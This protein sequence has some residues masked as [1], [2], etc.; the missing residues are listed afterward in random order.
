VKVSSNHYGVYIAEPY[1]IPVL[2]PA[3]EPKL[4][5]LV[6]LFLEEN[7]KVNLSA[8]RTEEQ[9]WAGNVLDSL[10]ALELPLFASWRSSPPPLEDPERSRRTGE[11]SGERENT[12]QTKTI[13]DVGTGGGFPLLPLAMALPEAQLTGLDATQKKVE[14]VGRMVH[15]LGLGNVRVVAGRAEEEGRKPEEREQYDVV[16]SRAVAETSVLLE[17]TSPFAK[18]GGHIILWKSMTIDKE[19]E[20]SL[21]ARAE[22]SAHLVA[23]HVYELPGNWGKRQLLVFEKGGSLH[24]KYPR[25]VGVPSKKPLR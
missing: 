14:A 25:P 15:V 10:A 12:Q 1:H 13:M 3:L 19:L 4:R 11:G 22:L 2:P 23:Q 16:T 5:N 24:E 8:F 6:Q 20:E 21:L 7:A 18:P 17:Y 9:C